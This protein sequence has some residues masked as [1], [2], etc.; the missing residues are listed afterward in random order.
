MG[1]ILGLKVCP[2]IADIPETVDL[3]VISVGR[4]RVSS[5]FEDC[6]RAGLGRV[7]IIGQGFAD[8]D[9]RGRGLQD[10]IARRAREARVRVLTPTRER[11]QRLVH[12]D[13][14][15]VK[16]P[17]RNEV[18]AHLPSSPTGLRPVSAKPRLTPIGKAIESAT[19]ELD[20]ADALD[21]LEATPKPD[22][23]PPHR[24]PERGPDFLK[25]RAH[26]PRKAV[27]VLQ[28]GR[29]TAATAALSHSGS[30]VGEDHVFDAVFEGGPPARPTSGEMRMPCTPWPFSARCRPQDQRRHRHRGRRHHV[31]QCLRGP[32][33]QLRGP[34]A[35]LAAGSCREYPTGSTS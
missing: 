17:F 27:I 23:R 14:A 20:I 26:Q 16:I 21:Y 25:Q 34:A 4:D 31:R 35:G 24:G 32:R 5:T 7:I 15:F 8:A 28:E 10:Q 12:F 13:A 3:A 9:E 11:R 1:D 22:H 18:S 2:E 19:P 29:S 6:I 30:L 33:P